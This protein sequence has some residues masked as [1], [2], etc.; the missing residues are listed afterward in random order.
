ME[1]ISTTN[2]GNQPR[3]D[4]Y[5]NYNFREARIS[6]EYSIKELAKEVGVSVPA[7][8]AYERLRCAPNPFV[9]RR[10]AR[11]LGKKTYEIF[12]PQLREIIREVCKERRGN[13]NQKYFNEIKERVES[14]EASLNEIKKYRELESLISPV[15]IERVLKTELVS[16][17]NTE[18]EIDALNLADK[19]K[20]VFN[21]L[22][23]REREVIK[24]RYGLG[25]GYTYSLEEVAE[26]FKVTREIVRRIEAKAIM[27]LQHPI[28][29]DRLEG[30]LE[31][32]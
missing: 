24:R 20:R 18:K 30:F 21:T 25:D 1:K 22:T 14:G 7:I 15:P 17:D 27:K 23:Y 2:L 11:I 26:E 13:E 5:Y 16:G 31:N 32:Y 19:P 3:K 28:R 10:I 6:A 12:P 8:Y 29:A 4:S 9:A